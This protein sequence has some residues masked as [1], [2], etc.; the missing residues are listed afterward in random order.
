[1]IGGSRPLGGKS[2]AALGLCELTS[3]GAAHFRTASLRVNCLSL[4]PRQRR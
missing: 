3:V 2:R 1:M 4:I